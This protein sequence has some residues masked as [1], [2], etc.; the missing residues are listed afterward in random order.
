MNRRELKVGDWI[1]WRW[2]ENGSRTFMKSR[3]SEIQGSLVNLSDDRLL[4]PDP[5]WVKLTEIQIERV[6]KKR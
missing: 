2:K 1:F 6:E 3:I 5:M 4:I